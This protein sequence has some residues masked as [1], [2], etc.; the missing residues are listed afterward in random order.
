VSGFSRH[1]NQ[2]KPAEHGSWSLLLTPFLIGV[3]LAAAMGNASEGVPLALAL[4]IVLALAA[5]LVRQPVGALVRVWRGRARR[6]GARLAGLW[7]VILSTVVALCGV[8]LVALGREKLLWLAIPAGVTLVAA[9]V[10]AAIYGPRGLALEIVGVLGL[11]LAAP[12]AYVAMSTGLEGGAVTAW[13]L[14]A[15]HSLISILYVRLRVA[16][17]HDRVSRSMRAGV[18]VSHL[19]AFAGVVVAGAVSALPWLVILPFGL[20][21]GRALWVAWRVPPLG[22]V[23]RFGFTEMGLGLGFVAL[24]V[25]AYVV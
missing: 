15:A 4:F 23:R 3:G 21:L 2:L 9:L 7:T 18:A 24:V 20:L 1:W 13:S 25:L 5:F 16:T 14:S 22:N 10:I 12:G 17:R 6:E 11:A 19:L 8:G